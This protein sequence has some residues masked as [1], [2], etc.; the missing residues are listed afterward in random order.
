MGARISER[1]AP[2]G[3]RICRDCGCWELNAC[4]NEDRGA[5]WWA[6]DDICSHCMNA[7]EREAEIIPELGDK[8]E[9]VVPDPFQGDCLID[10]EIVQVFKNGKLQVRDIDDDCKYTVEPK[11][12]LVLAK[13][14]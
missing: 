8:V 2:D 7:A 9:A 11:A 13:A 5:C 14:G 12:V 3:A 1:P 6:E 4:W 10:A